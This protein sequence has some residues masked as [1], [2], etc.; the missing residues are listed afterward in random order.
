MQ[1]VNEHMKR[2]STL[3]IVREVQIKTTMRY[4][5]TFTKIKKTIISVDKAMEKLGTSYIADGII[6]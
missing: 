1:M 4:N 6:K 3:L 5:F 2:Y